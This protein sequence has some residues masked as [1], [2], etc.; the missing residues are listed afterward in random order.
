MERRGVGEQ[1]SLS[2]TQAGSF[3][4]AVLSGLIGDRLERD[5]SALHQPTSA[6]M[7]GERIGLDESS[8]R[9]A[10]PQ[11]TG[12]LAVFIHGLTGDEFCW[13]WGA[14]DAYGAR[15]ASDLGCTA[16]YLRYNSGL[17]IS[18]NGSHGGGAARGAR[19]RRGRSTCSR[20]RW[21]ATRWA[22]W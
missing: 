11:A 10:F 15:L 20:S 4:L 1:T 14:E 9:D 18:E 21:S 8:L 2:T 16:V 19:A 12:R 5:G 13:S 22:A 17:H 7:H 3:G 6:R